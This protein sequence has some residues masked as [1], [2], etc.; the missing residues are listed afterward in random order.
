MILETVAAGI[1]LILV[2]SG[3]GWWMG[4]REAGRLGQARVDAALESLGN[5]RAIR[6]ELQEQNRVLLDQIVRIQR[7]SQGL[8]E[9]GPPPLPEPPS[10][11]ELQ[12]PQE[13]VKLC[14]LFKQHG[15]LMLRD[16]M[17]QRRTG[18]P[19]DFIVEGSR[20]QILEQGGGALLEM[21]DAEMEAQSKDRATG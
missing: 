11:E 4:W 8:Q 18:V 13:Y 3:A 19:W 9:I 5:E 1:A 2:S 21:F 15:T 14:S 16:G 10:E 20:R 6:A 17:R 12:P 7:A